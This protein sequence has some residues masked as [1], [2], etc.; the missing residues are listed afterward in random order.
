MRRISHSPG[1]LEASLLIF[2]LGS[3]R[4]PKPFT[5][6]VTAGARVRGCLQN[7]SQPCSQWLRI[8]QRVTWHTFTYSKYLC[9][10][11]AWPGF[12]GT[13]GGRSTRRSAASPC[14]PAH[15]SGL[16]GQAQRR[17]P[18]VLL[19]PKGARFRTR[20]KASRSQSYRKPL[21]PG[22]CHQNRISQK[23]SRD[24]EP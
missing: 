13:Q 2:Q 15:L 17:P 1:W 8:P 12:L 20:L 16:V 5:V 14:R 18:A 22:C 3:Q 23:Q 24:L 21:R 10:P 6:G 9:S 11:R 4:L 19:K 7:L